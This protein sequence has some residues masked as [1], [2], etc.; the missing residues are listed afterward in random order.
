MFYHAPRHAYYDPRLNTSA[1]N[2]LNN[3]A[4]NPAVQQQVGN[5]LFSLGKI[6]LDPVADWVSAKAADPAV[7]QQVGNALLSLGKMALNPVSDWAS[8]KLHD[9]IDSFTHSLEKQLF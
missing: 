5:A 3:I 4:A 1:T 2:F 8:A 7:Q 9:A 6:A